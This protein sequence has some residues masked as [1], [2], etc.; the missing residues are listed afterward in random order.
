VHHH[1]GH[2]YSFVP[3]MNF[4]SWHDAHLAANGL[5]CCQAKGRLLV[6]DDASE[7][8]FVASFVVTK[9]SSAWI[10]LV[11][12]ANDGVW[13]DGQGDA[14]ASTADASSGDIIDSPV[15]EDGGNVGGS[16]P[17]DCGSDANYD[18]KNYMHGVRCLKSAPLP[19]LVE[20]D[21]PKDSY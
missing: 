1:N 13:K 16:G 21:C 14:A 12:E 15:T 17:L 3:T 20:F 10:G 5:S 2:L 18:D 7:R 19:V 9:F 6:V 8:E 11:D 4:E